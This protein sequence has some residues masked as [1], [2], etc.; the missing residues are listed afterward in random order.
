MTTHLATH[1]IPDPDQLALIADDLTP[2]GRPFAEAFEAAC[3]T[4]ARRH[5]GLVHPSRVS[6]ILRES[7]GDFDP[8]RF[9]AMWAPACGREGYLDKTDMLAPIDPEVSKG[10][11]NKSVRLRRWRVADRDFAWTEH[12]LSRCEFGCKVYRHRDGL[13]PD[14]VIHSSAYGCERSTR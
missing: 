7:Y 3:L 2:I 12:A 10:N 1:P 4:D 8:R 14:R 11:G 6:A 9:S 5:L 13:A